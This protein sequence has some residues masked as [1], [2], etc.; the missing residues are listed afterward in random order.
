VERSL[1]EPRSTPPAPSRNWRLIAVLVVIALAA[2]LLIAKFVAPAYIRHS[3]GEPIP[4]D[5]HWYRPQEFVTKS[6]VFLV[7]VVRFEAIDLGEL[8][9]ELEERYGVHV[10]VRPAIQIESASVDIVRNQLRADSVLGALRRSYT[11]STPVGGGHRPVVIG[12]TDFDMYGESSGRRG[13]SVT[14]QN[15]EH[16]Y[17]VVSAAHL[18]PDF[19]ERLIERESIQERV[20]K[21]VAWNVAVL[22]LDLPDD[23]D[24]DN[25]SRQASR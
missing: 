14:V 2:P 4:V 1:E 23:T 8:A 3:V 7:P 19:I 25:I 21:V 11:V 18:E 15:R 12:L 17:A 13:Y 10:E 5:D 22:Y 6:G 9:A 24:P 16:G 20:R